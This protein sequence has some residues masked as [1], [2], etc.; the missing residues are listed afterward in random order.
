MPGSEWSV[1][2]IFLLNAV[3][4]CD[5]FRVCPLRLKMSIWLLSMC[6]VPLWGHAVLMAIKPTA[7]LWDGW[8][9]MP[10]LQMWKSKQK[11]WVTCQKTHSWELMGPVFKSRAHPLN[12][13]STLSMFP[14]FQRECC[15][16]YPGV[17]RVGLSCKVSYVS[18]WM[19]SLEVKTF[20]LSFCRHE[21]C[22]LLRSI[23]FTTGVLL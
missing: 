1:Y 5:V 11:A 9:F 10:I 22:M 4:L 23:S 19:L 3:L 14:V 17:L 8:V 16:F 12:H 7:A 21:K 18:K 15:C 6:Q 13:P 20:L 2:F